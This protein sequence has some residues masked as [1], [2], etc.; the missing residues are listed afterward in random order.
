[1]DEN[2]ASSI[3]LRQ[4]DELAQVLPLR[5]QLAYVEQP[6]EIG[7]QASGTAQGRRLLEG[8][9]DDAAMLTIHRLIK[10]EK[11]NCD[12]IDLPK[13]FIGDRNHELV[14][15]LAAGRYD[16][17]I[18]GNLNTSD[19]KDFY[20]LLSSPLYAKSPC[21]MVV[22]KNLVA[23]RK[24]ALLCGFGV[25]PHELAARFIAIVRGAELEVDLLV[26]EF[27]ESEAPIFLAGEDGDSS[28]PGIKALLAENDCPVQN[29]GVICGIP[30]QTADFFMDYGLV[31]TGFPGENSQLLELLAKIPTSVVL[32]R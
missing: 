19:A 24:A 13:I 11:V 17:F 10:T 21:P 12:F 22:V 15:E 20:R 18:E 23:S 2:L 3:A 29:S 16:L 32:C 31:F 7:R 30:E 25:D 6:D 28:L 4:V 26:Y 9:V 5:V 27:R 1:M 14:G 8:G